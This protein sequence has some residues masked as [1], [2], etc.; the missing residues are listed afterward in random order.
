MGYALENDCYMVISI[1]C[2]GAYVWED[3]PMNNKCIEFEKKAELEK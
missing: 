2:G 1:L 3:A